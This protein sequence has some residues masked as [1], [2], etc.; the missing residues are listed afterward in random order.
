MNAGRAWTV[1]AWLCC[2]AL[3]AWAALDARYV[4]DLSAF[5]PSRPTPRQ[6]LLVDQLRDGPGSRLILMALE[7]GDVE[8]RARLSA[9]LAHRLR[10][11]LASC[12]NVELE[13]ESRSRRIATASFFS[14]IATC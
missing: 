5:L 8:T 10:S 1:G 7:G 9:A 6:Q 4:A 12:S 11:D 14:P 2:V 13:A 3:A